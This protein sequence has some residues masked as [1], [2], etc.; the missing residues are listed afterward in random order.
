MLPPTSTEA[1]ALAKALA[2]ADAS[3]VAK[4]IV[5]DSERPESVMWGV[6][7][8]NRYF[9]TKKAAQ[10][11]R[12]LVH[13]KQAQYLTFWV[14]ETLYCRDYTGA[15]I[16]GIADFVDVL[17]NIKNNDSYN[18]NLRFYPLPLQESKVK[19]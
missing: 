18:I 12:F 11:S 19:P 6:E 9:S 10:T 7:I 17:F 2:E 16:F 14:D 13:F 8:L 4:V 15:W 1:T 3:A 5:A